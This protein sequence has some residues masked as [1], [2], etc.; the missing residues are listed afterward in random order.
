MAGQLR[1][2][3]GNAT[4]VAVAGG[5]AYVADRSMGLHAIDVT[6]PASPRFIGLVDTPGTLEGV[7]AAAGLVCIADGEAGIQLVKTQCP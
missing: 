4:A 2:P 1:I 6:T 5:T 3:G 7:S